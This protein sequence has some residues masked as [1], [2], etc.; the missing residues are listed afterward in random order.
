MVNYK[1]PNDSP[2]GDG[3]DRIQVLGNLWADVDLST[4]W[5]YKF[6]GCVDIVK[7]SRN[8]RKIKE[9]V[10]CEIERIKRQNLYRRKLSLN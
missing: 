9:I 7:I 4:G 10:H 5:I 1:N 3:H 8:R 6:I 2:I